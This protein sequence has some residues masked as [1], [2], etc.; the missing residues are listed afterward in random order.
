MWLGVAV[1]IEPTLTKLQVVIVYRPTTVNEG[2]GERRW[3]SATLNPFNFS[4]LLPA[5]FH[6]NNN[7]LGLTIK[8][9]FH[10]F[11]PPTHYACDKSCELMTTIKR[12]FLIAVLN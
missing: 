11:R 12:S 8:E 9:C 10:E 7:K 2:E 1:A 3:N 4:S 6:A 5:A